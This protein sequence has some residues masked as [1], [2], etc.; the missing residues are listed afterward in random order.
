M[1]TVSTPFA[2]PSFEAIQASVAKATAAVEALTAS[3]RKAALEGHDRALAVSKDQLAKALTRVAT[4]QAYLLT[5]AQTNAE[6]GVR[7][8]EVAVERAN[9]VF[10]EIAAL[11]KAY[12]VDAVETSKA[13][14]A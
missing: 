3:Y 2:A 13:A 6:A 9:A 11:A 8:Y 4:A 5:L 10:A 12:Q 14:L 7:S 1:T